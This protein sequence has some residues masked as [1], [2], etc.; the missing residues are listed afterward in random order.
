MCRV[1]DRLYHRSPVRPNMRCAPIRLKKRWSTAALQ[2][3]T[4]LLR[5]ENSLASW[6]ACEQKL[7][8]FDK[9]IRGNCV[10]NQSTQFSLE[11]MFTNDLPNKLVHSGRDPNEQRPVFALLLRSIRRLGRPAISHTPAPPASTDGK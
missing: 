5:R 1:F 4:A 8:R 6:I 7:G 2:N 10:L 3:V 11:A 9:L